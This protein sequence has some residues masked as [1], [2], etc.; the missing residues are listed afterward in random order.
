[1]KK[2]WFILR[3]QSERE[4]MIRDHLISRV[5]AAG[6]EE[7]FGRIL[8][9]TE[10]VTEIRSGKKRVMEQKMY[11]GYMLI[12]VMVNDDGSIPQDAWFLIIETQGISG[13][14]SS[15][16]KKPLPLPPDEAERIIHDMEEKREKPR[17]KVEF[18]VG[19]GVKIKAG[20]FENYDG[21][22]ED[23]DPGKGRVRVAVSIFGRSTSVD[24]EFANVEKV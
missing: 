1:M 12:E 18:Q 21:F 16:Q 19:E 8:V 22:V 15:D 3:V 6:K 17:P 10:H 2:N 14:V 4:S 23:V 24:V 9:P 20:P 13:F 7:L 5:K 11:P